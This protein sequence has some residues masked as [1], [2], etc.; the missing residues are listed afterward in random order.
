MGREKQ[1]F[2]GKIQRDEKEDI[3]KEEFFFFF[4]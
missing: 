2:G 1:A 3:E 4:F